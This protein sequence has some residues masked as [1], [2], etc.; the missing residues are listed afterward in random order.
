MFCL[1]Y[2]QTFKN[3]FANVRR[4]WYR[5]ERH[6]TALKGYVAV[7]LHNRFVCVGLQKR[8]KISL[9]IRCSFDLTIHTSHVRRNL[10]QK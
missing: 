3:Q 6:V 10:E 1:Y 5:K 9:H 7:D 8:L 2:V 4:I